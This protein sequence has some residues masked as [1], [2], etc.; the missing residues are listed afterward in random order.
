MVSNT[1]I[2]F[3][4]KILV[5]ILVPIVLFLSNTL[6]MFNSCYIK[7]E[8]SKENFQKSTK[9]SD[10][11]RL[12]AST[13]L[14]GF[15]RDKIELVK[16]EKTGL[17]DERELKHLNDVKALTNNLFV[18]EKLCLF[19]LI[20][21]IIFIN[22]IEKNAFASLS[23]LFYGFL[24]ALILSF[25]IFLIVYFSFDWFFIKFHEIFFPQGFWSFDEQ[26]TLIQLY[27]EKFWFDSGVLL[28][29]LVFFESLSLVGIIY[30]LMRKLKSKK[31]KYIH[32]NNNT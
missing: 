23:S 7:F 31:L 32:I 11:Q 6:L 10:E 15:V 12:N 30:L 9:F 4:T 20:S 27:P 25:C 1:R 19:L 26:S 3:L 5:I 21:I 2:I 24:L 28:L 29:F 22:L 13:E 18:T 14:I 17:Y 8:Y 16:I